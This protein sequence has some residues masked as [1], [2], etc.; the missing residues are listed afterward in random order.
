MFAIFERPNTEVR[1]LESVWGP[2]VPQTKHKTERKSNLGNEHKLTSKMPLSV[3]KRSDQVAAERNTA[4]I[5]TYSRTPI[6]RT[7]R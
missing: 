4:N 7:L 6:T 5:S 1:N 2:F 3:S